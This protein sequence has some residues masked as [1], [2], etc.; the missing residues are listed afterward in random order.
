MNTKDKTQRKMICNWSGFVL[1]FVL[2]VVMPP[3]SSTLSLRG[4]RFRHR[5]LVHAAG[6]AALQGY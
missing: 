2:L 3:F 1:F 6:E 5:A 4:S